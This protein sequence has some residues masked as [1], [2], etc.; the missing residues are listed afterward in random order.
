MLCTS[1]SR[2]T[3]LIWPALTRSLQSAFCWL[4]NRLWAFSFPVIQ[5]RNTTR[6][7]FVR[8]RFLEFVNDEETILLFF[9]SGVFFRNGFGQYLYLSS[10]LVVL[11]LPCRL[12]YVNEFYFFNLSNLSSFFVD[13]LE[14]GLK[15]PM[16]KTD[17]DAEYAKN[18]FVR[19]NMQIIASNSLAFPN[20][21]IHARI[22]MSSLTKENC[23]TW[24][25][26]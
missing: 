12:F 2:T 25:V 1:S 3:V 26:S 20:A 15:I 19:S 4:S 23:W 22:I 6:T 18:F 24:I 8:I 13:E 10:F 14:T 9:S 21:K 17:K 5:E 7:V 16:K 11:G